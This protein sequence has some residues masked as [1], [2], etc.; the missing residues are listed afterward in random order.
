MKKK[1]PAFLSV[2]RLI[3]SGVE[4]KSEEKKNR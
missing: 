4:Y 2:Y 1:T 3:E